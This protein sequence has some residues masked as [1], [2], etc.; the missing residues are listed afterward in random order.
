MKRWAQTMQAAVQMLAELV[1]QDWRSL[2]EWRGQ[3]AVQGPLFGQ[4]CTWIERGA[5][6]PIWRR[7]VELRQEQREVAGRVRDELFLLLGN[8]DPREAMVVLCRLPLAR[9]LGYSRERLSRQLGVSDAEM[10][11]W[12]EQAFDKMGV[13]LSPQVPMLWALRELVEGATSSDNGTYASEMSQGGSSLAKDP[14]PSDGHLAPAFDPSPLLRAARHQPVFDLR[15]HMSPQLELAIR[16]A[17]HRMGLAERERVEG[18]FHEEDRLAVALVAERMK[19]E[20]GDGKEVRTN[21]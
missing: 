7:F 4:L 9:A 20:L 12:E 16:Q 17:F 15:A 1:D 13:A 18:L 21:A 5:G 11:A 19:L 8:L 3:S 2:D 10:L 6:Q 14:L